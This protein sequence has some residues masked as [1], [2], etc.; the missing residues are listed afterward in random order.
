[1]TETHPLP[2]RSPARGPRDLVVLTGADLS[3]AD[4]EAVA[5]S[6]ARVSLDE[7]ARGRMQEARDVIETLV[8]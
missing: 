4:V 5:R 2:E 1:M 7:A 3:V 6:D 8:A